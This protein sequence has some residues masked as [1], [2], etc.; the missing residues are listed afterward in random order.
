[1]TI[2]RSQSQTMDAVGLLLVRPVFAHGHLYTAFSRVVSRDQLKV[3]V[4]HD[5]PTFYDDEL[6]ESEVTYTQNIVY[7]EILS[8]D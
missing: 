3:C 2:N 5:K 1:M 7:K 4:A 8:S 6:D